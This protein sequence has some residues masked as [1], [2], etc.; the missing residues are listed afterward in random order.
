[1]RSWIGNK[2]LLKHLREQLGQYE[3]RL[4]FDNTAELFLIFFNVI[5]IL[6]AMK[7]LEVKSTILYVT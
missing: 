3:F 5:M 1:M 2:Y 6:G 7:Y 4:E